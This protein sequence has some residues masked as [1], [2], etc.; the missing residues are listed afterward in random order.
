MK[1]KKAELGGKGLFVVGLAE[2]VIGKV[3]WQGGPIVWGEGSWGY[4][5]RV[6]LR[7]KQFFI[8]LF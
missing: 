3:S 1:L 7:R 5:R 2:L 8:F 6:R 4:L